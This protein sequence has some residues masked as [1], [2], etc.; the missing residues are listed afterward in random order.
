MK[1]DRDRTAVGEIDSDRTVAH[2]RP[3]AR[4]PRGHLDEAPPP[5]AI[6][7]LIPGADRYS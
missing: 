1:R 4:P 6:M 2:L 7:F 3:S 5:Q